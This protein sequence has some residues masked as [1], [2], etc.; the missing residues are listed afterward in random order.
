[1]KTVIDMCPFMGITTWHDNDAKAHYSGEGLSLGELNRLDEYF[2][3]F[4]GQ[5]FAR[6][7]S[8][9]LAQMALDNVP[10]PDGWTP[11]HK[12]DCA[13]YNEPAYPKGEC[14]CS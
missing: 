4:E 14:D 3:R 13:V 11:G 6:E 12:S 2:A 1:M 9:K 10:I 5:A 7:K 8:I